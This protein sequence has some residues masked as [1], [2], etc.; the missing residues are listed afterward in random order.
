M[1]RIA[2]V[3]LV[4]L[5]SLAP[6]ANAEGP[7][8][9]EKGGVFPV[10]A[11]VEKPEEAKA[12]LDGLDKAQDSKDEAKI[13]AAVMAMVTKRHKDFVP[14][15]KKL[16]ADKRFAV[17]AVAA[18]ALGSQA[19]KTVAP[20]LMRAVTVENKE[21]GIT[22]DG[23]LKGAAIESLGRLGVTGGFNDI[24]KLAEAMLR[25]PEARQRAA[26]EVLRGVVRY[27]GL[28]K[29]KRAVSFLIDEVDEPQAGTI[30]GTTPPAEYWKARFEIW[31]RIRPDVV[32]A[33]KE[34]TGKEFET[35]RRW[36]GWL[37]TDGKKE[38]M[39]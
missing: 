9:G 24:M 39:K 33:L 25:D 3:T 19:D 10:V 20:V 11:E 4:L 37:E 2:A 38:G 34:I 13:L 7:V 35:E 1:Q 12:L 23:P 18:E 31:T 36:K 8:K 21:R 27:L 14:E 29:E 17:A 15:L 5:L 6:S 30:T 26:P 16:V 28:T 22:K 32:W